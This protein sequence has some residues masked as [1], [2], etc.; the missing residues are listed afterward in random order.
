MLL[1]IWL[2]SIAGHFLKVFYFH[3][4]YQ[5]LQDVIN[6]KNVIFVIVALVAMLND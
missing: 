4:Y 6:R 3:R 2:L 5:I 1:L